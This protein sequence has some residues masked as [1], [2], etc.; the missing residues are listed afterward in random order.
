MA[1]LFV[2][3][4]NSNINNEKNSIVSY[5]FLLYTMLVALQ[6][7]AIWSELRYND[8]E[9]FI[10]YIVDIKEFEYKFR[11]DRIVSTSIYLFF[12]NLLL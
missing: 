2:S 5:Y 6:K 11:D 8:F 7:G 1:L 3:L 4:G 10:I 12:F 9:N